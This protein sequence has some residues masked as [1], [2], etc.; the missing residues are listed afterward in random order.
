MDF[1][2]LII[3]SFT[4]II[5]VYLTQ[6]PKLKLD[7]FGGF[8][9]KISKVFPIVRLVEAIASLKRKGK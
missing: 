9:C 2:L 8:I 7:A 6:L 1:N 3:L 4:L 5:I